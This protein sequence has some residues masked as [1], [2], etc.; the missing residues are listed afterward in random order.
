MAPLCLLG[1]WRE[2][3][4]NDASGDRSERD[5]GSENSSGQGPG[6]VTAAKQNVGGPVTLYVG[7]ETHHLAAKVA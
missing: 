7:L 2:K 5:Q 6:W 1:Q 3:C 4:L